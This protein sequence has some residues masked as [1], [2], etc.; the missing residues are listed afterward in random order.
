MF[1]QVLKQDGQLLLVMWRELESLP[2]DVD[3]PSRD[4]FLGSPASILPLEEPFE[5]DCRSLRGTANPLEAVAIL[6]GMALLQEAVECS[7][8]IPTL[9]V[10]EVVVSKPSA[11]HTKQKQ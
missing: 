3:D 4:D 2:D 7:G 8:G 5:W 6:G 10:E 11:A 1:G 9:N